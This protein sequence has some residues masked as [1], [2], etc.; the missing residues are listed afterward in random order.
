M[1][2]SKI[3][4]FPSK[5]PD[6]GWRAHI[7]PA[8]EILYFAEGEHTVTVNDRAFRAVPGDLIL[9]PF[10]ASHALA[11]VPGTRTLHY[12]LKVHPELL[13]STFADVPHAYVRAFFREPRAESVYFP[14]ARVPEGIRAQ[15]LRMIDMLGDKCVFE[16]VERMAQEDAL[17]FA[18][19]RCEAALLL[20]LISRHLWPPAHDEPA[21][22]DSRRTVQRIMEAISYIEKHYA[23]PITPQ[24]C[25]AHLCMSYSHFAKQFH[26]VTG[27]TFKQYLTYIRISHAEYELLTTADSVTEIAL[28]AGFNN[29]SHFIATYRTLRGK[30]PLETRKREQER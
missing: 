3:E 16:D 24:D 2:K 6:Y 18:T 27:R 17:L 22:S 20:L 8:M 4:F 23:A 29:V 11:I 9:I 26:T 30:T 15:L 28:R 1:T 14:A 10:N 5:H 21:S 12:A 13:F 25:A 19:L 7:H